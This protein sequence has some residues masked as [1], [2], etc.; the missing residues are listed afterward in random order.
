MDIKLEKMSVTTAE[1]QGC[2]LDVEEQITV[3]KTETTQT[4]I[5][6]NNK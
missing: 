4:D 6:Q 5:Q 3:L 1:V 2:I